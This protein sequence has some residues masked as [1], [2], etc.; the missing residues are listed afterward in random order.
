MKSFAKYPFLATLAILFAACDADRTE[1][2][3]IDL[4]ADVA[5]L[6]AFAHRHAPAVERFNIDAATGGTF[7]SSRGVRLTFPA[8]A[9]VTASGQPVT[10]NVEVSVQ[11]V[12]TPSEM[13][14]SNRPT[15]TANGE[16]LISFGEFQVRMRQGGNELRLAAN[17]VVDV[18]AP[19]PRNAGAP[20]GFR[21]VPLWN[22][23]TTIQQTMQGLDW[24]AQQVSIT[25]S[26]RTARGV[27][28]NSAPG[29]AALNPNG[30]NLVFGLTQPL[31]L[32]WVNCDRLY[33][34]PRPKT[35][36]LTYFGQNFAPGTGQS[37]L[38]WQP[39]GL[40]FKPLGLNS[41]IKFYNQILTPPTGREGFYSYQNS[42]PIGMEGSFLAYSVIDG[43]F[44]VEVRHNVTIPSPVN[45]FVGLTFNPQ[46]V[47]ESAFLA[48]IQSLDA[49]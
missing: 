8:G 46:P 24:Q 2:P 6:T 40:F 42:I 4:E 1:E 34:D 26:I 14:L 45:G 41:V 35:T 30:Q 5:R 47:S 16:I 7:T 12:A 33:S 10:G 37:Y 27:T 28:W 38:G 44:Y 3:S 49:Q 17:R 25:Q 36:V 21:E 32:N 23:D 11:N 15:E 9:F 29:A 20:Q 31:Q 13:V 39:S 43:R 48:A 22:G 18:Q 19:A